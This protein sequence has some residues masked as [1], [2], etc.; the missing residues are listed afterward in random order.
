MTPNKYLFKI[1]NGQ[2][3]T[4]TEPKRNNLEYNT[5]LHH[6]PTPPLNPH[7]LNFFFFFFIHHDPAFD[8]I[9]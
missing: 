4:E 3:S 2:K 9:G 5:Q 6:I 7:F 8:P 1:A